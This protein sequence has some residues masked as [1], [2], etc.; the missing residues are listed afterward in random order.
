MKKDHI[1]TNFGMKN[2]N[3]FITVQ[4]A[5]GGSYDPSLVDEGYQAYVFDTDKGT[6][7][8]SVAEGTSNEPH[9]ATD[10][11]LAKVIKLNECLTKTKGTLGTP[12]FQNNKV[13]S[14]DPNLN[15]I[16]V[17]KVYAIKVI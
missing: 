7:E 2:T 11:I 13:M 17:N 4:C 3:P 5:A 16:K 15:F 9:F 6:L 1:V 14:V 10:Q 12:L 8:I